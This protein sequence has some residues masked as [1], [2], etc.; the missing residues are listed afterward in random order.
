M[1]GSEADLEAVRAQALALDPKSV[2]R[3]RADPFL[4][5]FNAGVVRDELARHRDAITATGVRVDWSVV[6]GIPRIGSALLFAHGRVESDPVAGGEVRALL[7]E[8]RPLR[9]LLLSDARVH[10]MRGGLSAKEVARIESGGGALDVG[11]DLT[12]LAALY[13][14]NLAALKGRTSVTAAEVKRAG[15]LGG[16]LRTRIRPKG[17]APA[18]RSTEAQ[19]AWRDLRDRVWTLLLHAH[20]HADRAGGA[21]WGRA[22]A[23]RLP[24]LQS[25]YVVRRR[26]KSEAQPVKPP[27]PAPPP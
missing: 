16:T 24:T 4:A 21:L 9:R 27:P 10:A 3:L 8:A 26:A 18:P 2:V 19:R 12:D 6:D 13:A 11:Q 25:R 23:D 5:V 14:P 1:Q 20:D 15:E 7:A 22:V 17:A